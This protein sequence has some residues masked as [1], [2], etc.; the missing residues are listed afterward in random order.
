MHRFFHENEISMHEHP[1]RGHLNFL[2]ELFA[3]SLQCVA[4]QI[5]CSMTSTLRHS[6]A[7]SCVGVV[8]RC[9]AQ[10][11]LEVGAAVRTHALR[12]RDQPSEH[13]VAWHGVV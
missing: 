1:L 9:L 5:F 12:P 2:V 6:F 3:A 4:V 11:K 10:G 7:D 8:V 13:H